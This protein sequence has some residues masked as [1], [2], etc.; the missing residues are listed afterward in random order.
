MT[1]KRLIELFDK[2]PP[3]RG[4]Q[5]ILHY[6]VS[7][8]LV[9]AI[10]FISWLLETLLKFETPNSLD[11][12]FVLP[13][14]FS[15]VFYRWP[16]AMFTATMATMAFDLVITPPLW[17][18]QPWKLENIVNFLVMVLTVITV[19]SIKKIRFLAAQS[20]RIAEEQKRAFLSAVLS[21]ISHDFKTPLVTVIGV[22][23]ALKEMRSY[24][25]QMHCRQ[26][27]SGA[28]EE[29][30]KLNR[31]IGNLLEIS[32]L[33]T[34][35]VITH[36]EPTPLRDLLA[37][38][39]KSLRHLV[40]N[41]HILINIEKGFPFLNVNQTLIEL[42]F[43]NL[44]ENAIKYAE[45]DATISITSSYANRTATIDV[46]DDG[47]GIPPEERGAVF[48]KFYR[49]PGGDRKVGGTGL[50]LYICRGIIEAHGGHIVILGG[51]RYKGACF[52]ITLPASALTSIEAQ[53]EREVT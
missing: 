40:E 50:G 7:A 41:Q 49:S 43:S 14:F 12:L 13:V 10:T 34:G 11:L 19:A 47:P 1:V 38:P 29:A 25:N 16:V 15:S 22:L 26:L 44:L 52:R 28:L 9:V 33:E 53:V 23:S 6:L 20:E 42:V 3:V 24:D 30:E 48:Q 8:I 4:K 17:V 51:I 21:S 32:R 39:L 35:M 37:R 18:W 5:E 45:P 31:F 2:T 46:E 36:R 27:V